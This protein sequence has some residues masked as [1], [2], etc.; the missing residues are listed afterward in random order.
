MTL[1][2]C[3]CSAILVEDEGATVRVAMRN[4][5]LNKQT[6]MVTANCCRCDGLF[7]INEGIRRKGA[8]VATKESVNLLF[9]IGVR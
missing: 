4:W 1:L 5:R 7:V 6:G 3:S 2:R 8:E 9:S